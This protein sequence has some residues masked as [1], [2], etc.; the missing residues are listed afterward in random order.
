[1]NSASEEQHEVENKKNRREIFDTNQKEVS[2]KGKAVFRHQL[3][4]GN[5]EARKE[6]H[7]TR[8]FCFVAVRGFRGK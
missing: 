1:M 5:Q 6:G 2:E 3:F 4:E 8:G 7:K